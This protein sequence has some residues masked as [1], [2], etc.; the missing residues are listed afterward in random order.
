MT[1]TCDPILLEEKQTKFLLKIDIEKP[2]DLQAIF[3]NNNPMYIEIGSGKG[4]FISEYALIHPEWNFIGFELKQK[5]VDISLRKLD[6]V[7]HNNVRLATFI[8]DE[9]I[10]QIIPVNTIDGVFIQHPDPWPK[11][12]HFRRRL[13]QQELLDALSKILKPGGFIQV[14]TDHEDYAQWIWKEF[15][16]R[17]DYSSMSEEGISFKPMLDEHVITFY[18]REQ[19]RLGFEPRHM[20]FKRK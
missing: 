10:A 8:I 20:L 5:R 11:R 19:R 9:N 12:K 14:S 3:Q 18:E 4:E 2:L 17:D 16:T 15:S 13:V 1:K 6:L 7:R